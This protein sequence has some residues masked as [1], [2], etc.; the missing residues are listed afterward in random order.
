MASMSMGNTDLYFGP[1]VLSRSASASQ[2][3]RLGFVFHALFGFH[4]VYARLLLPAAATRLE[5]SR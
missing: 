2:T 4:K 5:S 3:P 1:A